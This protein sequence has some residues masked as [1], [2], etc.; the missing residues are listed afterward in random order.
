MESMSLEIGI[1]AGLLKDARERMKVALPKDELFKV[2][3]SCWLKELGGIIRALETYV[4]TDGAAIVLVPSDPK[5]EK[6]LGLD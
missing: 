4:Q 3:R 6:Y 2:H 5:S 1:I